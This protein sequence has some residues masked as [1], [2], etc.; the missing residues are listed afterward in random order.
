MTPLEANNTFCAQYYTV[1]RDKKTPQM[2]YKFETIHFNDGTNK[3]VLCY[4]SF[5]N[6]WMGS[7]LTKEYTRKEL[8]DILIPIG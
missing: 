4:L 6:I 1:M 8:T 2:Y 3:N 5:D 7:G